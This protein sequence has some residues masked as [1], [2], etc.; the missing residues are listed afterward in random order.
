MTDEP[1]P[2]PDMTPE[3]QPKEQSH[4]AKADVEMAEEPEDPVVEDQPISNENGGKQGHSK[5]QD[6][7][8]QE[9]QVSDQVSTTVI[10]ISVCQNRL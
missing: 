2:A 5:I 8:D 4:D 7:A 3:V 10:K 9:I 6:P 1:Q